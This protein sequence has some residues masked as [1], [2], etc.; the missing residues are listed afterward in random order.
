VTDLSHYSRSF[1]IAL[2]L[3]A[4]LALALVIFGPPLA[5][6]QAQANTIDD[7]RRELA[8]Y[9]R[10]VGSKAELEQQLA[11]LSRR[12]A[13]SKYYV[14]G[15]TPALASANIQKYLKSIV[16]RNGAEVIS[17]QIVAA[18]N[19]AED[20][21]VS[22][23]VHMRADIDAAMAILHSVE[24]GRPMLF[25]DDLAINAR[26]VRGRTP[27]DPPTVQLD[28]QFQLTGYIGNSS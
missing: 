17:T 4:I 25:V 28:M 22:L 2:L 27:E 16:T 13:T 1:A 14:Q 6:Y 7:G 26:P 15:A 9:R 21:Q 11:G 24:S 8:T 5:L 23:R 3:L 12:S 20:N 10:L 19:D 18:Q